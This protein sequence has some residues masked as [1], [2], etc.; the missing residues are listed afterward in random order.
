MK[1]FVLHPW[2]SAGEQR[3][4]YVSVGESQFIARRWPK[5]TQSVAKDPVDT[6]YRIEN[7]LIA[8][9]LWYHATEREIQQ[10]TSI[11]TL[12][13]TAFALPFVG[14]VIVLAFRKGT[15]ENP[16]AASFWIY[17]VY[18]LP[19]AA[20]SY[21]ERYSLP[22]LGVKMLLVVYGVDTIMQLIPARHAPLNEGAGRAQRKH[23]R[24]DIREW[25]DI[26]SAVEAG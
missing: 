1:A 2:L 14:L 20:I 19:Y 7:R 24:A 10:E 6:L 11:M 25:V 8:A 12:K 13:R 3:D 18:L 16:I 9:C 21:Y 17:I 15:L 23:H 22:L 5:V 4:E 26:D